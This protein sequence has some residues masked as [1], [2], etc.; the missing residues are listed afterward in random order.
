MTTPLFLLFGISLNVPKPTAL[1]SCSPN[2]TYTTSMALRPAQEF[3]T[4]GECASAA[5]Q[6]Q[7]AC[8][9]MVRAVLL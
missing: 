7:A 2:C 9:L 6:L 1:W 5:Q 3:G 4:S 8:A